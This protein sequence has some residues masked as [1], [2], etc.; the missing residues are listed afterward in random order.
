MTQRVRTACLLSAL[1]VLATACVTLPT[2]RPGRVTA[3]VLRVIDGD[4]IEVSISRQAYKVR[5]I[6]IDTPET[7]HPTKGIEPFGPEAA[8]K[9]EALVGG[10]VV[11]LEKDVSETDKYGRLLRYVWIG[12]LMVNAELV[13]LGYA[14]ISTYPPDVKY[15]DRFLR[16]QREARQDCRG[17]WAIAAQECAL[18]APTR[19]PGEADVM[20]RYIF[21]DGIVPGVESDEYVE[22]ANQ[23]PASVHLAGWQLNAGTPGEDFVFPDTV[24]QPE[25]ILRVYTNELH[26]ETGG[27]S[28]GIA[29]AIWNNK[30]DCGYL[31]DADDRLVSEYCY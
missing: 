24:L 7:K 29:H 6:G 15:Q 22:I 17:L 8:A 14:Q 11:E 27:F 19:A 31:H 3:Q 23:G 28:F 30:G 12:D 20:I 4:T 16:L 18:P 13:R 26:P 21:Y 10:K 2:P 9:N 5:Y 1:L 25:Q